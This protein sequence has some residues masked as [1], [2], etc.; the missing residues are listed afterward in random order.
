MRLYVGVTDSGWHKRLSSAK[1]DEVNFWK[2][3]GGP[4][5]SGLNRGELFLFKLHSPDNFIV[6]GGYFVKFS[7]LPVSLAWLAFGEKNGVGTFP[8]FL[9]RIRKYRKA[10]PGHDPT[11]G[12]IVLT[13]PFWFERDDWIP[14]PSDWP[15][16]S[17]QGKGYDAE[18]GR[19]YQLFAQV[20]DR[21]S[22]PTDKPGT[23]ETI[24]RYGRT[25]V[26]YRLGQ[27]GFQ[28]LVTDAYHRRCAVTGESTLPVLE[29]AHVKPYATDGPHS[30]EN[31][32]LL[33]SDMHTLFD[34]GLLTITPEFKLEVSSQIQEQYSNGKLY[35]SY[36]GSELR[37]MPENPK[38]RPGLDFLEW[39]NQNVFV[40]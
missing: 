38:E 37:S 22:M 2:P 21:L 40:P 36:H 20:Q 11:I 34:R 16:S 26:N 17:V 27:G 25:D 39:H 29:A 8:E 32:L 3:S 1:P 18:E 19:G 14:A 15:M 5:Q 4:D 24:A 30:L 23:V 31:G 10:D 12:N 7:K 35:Y 6:G 13:Q 28:V 33:R 9:A